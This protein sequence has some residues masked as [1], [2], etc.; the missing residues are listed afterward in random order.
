MEEAPDPF[1]GPRVAR[2]TAAAAALGT[3]FRL[4]STK[5]ARRHHLLLNFSE[6]IVPIFLNLVYM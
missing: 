6:L 3:P 2:F 1:F 4:L 5:Q